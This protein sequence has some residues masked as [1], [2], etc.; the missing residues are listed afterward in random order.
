MRAP[1]LVRFV[2]GA[3][4]M[5][6]AFALAACGSKQQ[7][8][9]ETVTIQVKGS[10]TMVNLAQAWAEAYNQVAPN[11]DVEVSG[12]G[13]GVGIAA[14]EKG[15]I[16]IANSSRNMKPEEIEQA[17]SNT[18]KEPV[19]HTIGYD[20]LAVY[21]HK[22]NPAE[23][24]SF[25]QLTAI[26]AEGGPTEKWSQIGVRIPGASGDVI[27]R[28]S[29]QSS[30]GTYEFFREHV[31]AKKDFKLGSRDMNGSKE[32]VELVAN[33]PTAIG[34]S[35]MGYATPAVKMLRVARKAGEPAVTPSVQSTLD[36]TYPLARPLFMYTLGEPQGEVKRY[37][38]WCLSPDGQKIVQES[39]YVPLAG[40]SSGS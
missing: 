6:A 38:D 12:G 2:V 35:G 25:D 31:L 30:S 3:L 11:V 40:G 22:D 20:A 21:V 16:D 34:Y 36:H 17:K 1:W 29:R 39:G 18:G 33:T 19:E 32:V 27:V 14:L 4:G 15:A 9:A 5:G 23:E 10:D 13:S 8:A 37:I 7:P 28:V 26:F 24:I